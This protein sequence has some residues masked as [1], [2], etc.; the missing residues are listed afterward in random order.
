MNQNREEVLFALPRF[1]ESPRI[2]PVTT[3]AEFDVETE[4]GK[5][6]TRLR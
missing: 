3:L 5:P 6:T 1:N 2:W 4:H